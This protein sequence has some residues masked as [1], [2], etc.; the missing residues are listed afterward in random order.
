MTDFCKVGILNFADC[1]YEVFSKGPSK[2]LNELVKAK[3][4]EYNGS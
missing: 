1:K 4:G 2:W 3:S